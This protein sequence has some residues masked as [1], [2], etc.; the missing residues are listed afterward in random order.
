MRIYIN[1]A[2]L[3]IRVFQSVLF[4][5][6]FFV[7]KMSISTLSNTVMAKKRICFNNLCIIRI[8]PYIYFII[9]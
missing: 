1:G 6:F 8:V 2:K 9:Y 7:D 4:I 3:S 5:I